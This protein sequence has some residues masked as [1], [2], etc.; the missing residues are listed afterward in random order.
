MTGVSAMPT[1]LT[2]GK[3]IFEGDSLG[4]V[5]TARTRSHVHEA[6]GTSRQRFAAV[7]TG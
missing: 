3:P 2:P 6:Y 1:R 7:R 5:R 4:R